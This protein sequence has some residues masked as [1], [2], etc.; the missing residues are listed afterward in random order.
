MNVIFSKFLR[1]FLLVFFDDILIYSK[2]KVEHLQHLRKVLSVMRANKLFAKK[3]KCY[4]G[5]NRVEYLGHFLSKDG[6]STDLVKIQAVKDWPLPQTIKQL[7]GFLGLTGYYRRFVKGYGTIA[8]P[9]I[10]MLKKDNFSW[11]YKSKVAFTKLKE[12][13]IA[14]PVLALPDF[15]KTFIV[16]V[17]ASGYGIGVVLMQDHHPLA[18]INRTLNQQQQVLSIYEKELIVVVFAVQKWRHY[19]LNIHFVI[20][21]DH[22][23]LKYILDQRLTTAFQQKWLVKLM[24]FNFSIEYKEGK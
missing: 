11:T 22:R 16:E 3:S 7:R 10:D 23:S 1:K 15:N 18:F 17:N 12:G 8:R 6:V 21:T 20:K 4:F 13:M 9:L 5:V 24:E 19:L 2:S 14:A